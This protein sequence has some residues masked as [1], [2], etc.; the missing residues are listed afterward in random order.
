MDF[1]FN[2]KDMLDFYQSSMNHA[3]LITG[4]TLDENEKPLKWKI[5]N[6][7]GTELGKRRIFS[8][9]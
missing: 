5:E 1:S 3:M 8:S 4:V 9:K 6:S 7:W 2:K